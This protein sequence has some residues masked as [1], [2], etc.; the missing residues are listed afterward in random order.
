MSDRVRAA[1]FI[2]LTATVAPLA[3]TPAQAAAPAP[4]ADRVGTSVSTHADAL[5]SWQLRLVI[6]ALRHG[7]P[8][9]G[10]MLGQLSPEAG[11]YLK[12]YA[13]MIADLLSGGQTSWQSIHDLLVN[14]SV[15]EEYASAIADVIVAILG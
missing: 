11:E 15:P 2:A 8:L 3:A 13:P 14:Q 5:T 9:M 4:T 12:M 1:L 7:G 6:L 10:Q